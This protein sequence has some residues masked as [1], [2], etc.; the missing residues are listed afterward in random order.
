MGT[1]EKHGYQQTA[2]LPLEVIIKVFYLHIH[3]TINN[4]TS[5]WSEVFELES[6]ILTL[7]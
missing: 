3:K 7:S 2:V 6:N 5:K 4:K 1:Q